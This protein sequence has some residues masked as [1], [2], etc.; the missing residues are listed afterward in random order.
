M[1]TQMPTYTLVIKPVAA[2][3]CQAEILDSNEQE[4]F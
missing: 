2:S 1:L 4:L 3:D